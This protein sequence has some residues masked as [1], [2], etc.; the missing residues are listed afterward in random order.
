MNIAPGPSSRHLGN[1]DDLSARKQRRRTQDKEAPK[2]TDLLEENRLLRIELD[3]LKYGLRKVES[4]FHKCRKELNL[5][6]V[7]LAKY[8]QQL[9][10][11]FEAGGGDLFEV[12]KPKHV[13]DSAGNGAGL[14]HDDTNS[15]LDGESISNSQEEDSST[16]SPSISQAYDEEKSEEQR[17]R[18]DKDPYARSEA[19]IRKHR[20][21]R[22][23]A[24]TPQEELIF[25][26]AYNKHGCRWKLF[27]DSLPGRSRRQIQSHGSYLIRQGKLLKKNSRPWQRRKPGSGSAAAAPSISV[28]EADAEGEE[29]V[30]DSD[31]E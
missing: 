17:R 22:A 30:E 25:M 7:L 13:A 12:S 28:R 23:P 21:T 4:N 3:N 31:R 20:R 15:K 10:E 18:G 8:R 14:K 27:Q 9:V 11:L 19:T 2:R 1:V 26:Q 6:E 5:K 16:Y 29:V 24:W